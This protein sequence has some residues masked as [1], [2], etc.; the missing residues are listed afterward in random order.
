[1]VL[2]LT[3]SMACHYQWAGD[4]DSSAVVTQSGKDNCK[5]KILSC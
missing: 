2:R 5:S 3:S 4:L 1:M